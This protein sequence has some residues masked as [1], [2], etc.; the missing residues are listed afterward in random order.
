MDSKTLKEF[1]RSQ[2]YNEGLSNRLS[3]TIDRARFLGMIVGEAVSRKVD[4]EK[5]QL[6]FK[7]PETE[8]PSAEAMR[9]LIDVDDQPASIKGLQSGIVEAE[10][11]IQPSEPIPVAPVEDFLVDDHEDWDKDLRKY[12]I[13]ESDAE[14]SDED[15][16]LIN[17]EKNPN[18]LYPPLH[19]LF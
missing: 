14:D 11:S 7:V 6:K 18:P 3:A 16:M 12:T 19:N 9:S 4:P 15:P 5:V 2:D 8:D 13:P 10:E 1:S 17:R